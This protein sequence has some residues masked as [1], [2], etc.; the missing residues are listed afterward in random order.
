[1]Q[2][3]LPL[4]EAATHIDISRAA[5]RARIRRNTVEAE[6]RDGRWFVLVDVPDGEQYDRTLNFGS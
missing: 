5:L 3:W 6:K 2:K 4:R 1:M